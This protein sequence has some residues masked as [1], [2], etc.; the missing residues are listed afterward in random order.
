MAFKN[1]LRMEEQ[2]RRAGD[3]SKNYEDILKLY[4]EIVSKIKNKREKDR[5]QGFCNVSFCFQW[6][7]QN[8]EKVTH[9]KGRLC[10]EQ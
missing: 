2:I 4:T 10:I 5:V 9:I 3:D 6:C 1:C 8:T 7:S